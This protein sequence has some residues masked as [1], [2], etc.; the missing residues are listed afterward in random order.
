[1]IG[2]YGVPKLS[3]T[4]Y[5]H[6]DICWCIKCKRIVLMPYNVIYTREQ[7]ICICTSQ[8]A[9]LLYVLIVNWNW[10]SYIGIC[11]ENEEYIYIYIYIYILRENDLACRSKNVY[12]S[13]HGGMGLCYPS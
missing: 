13:M 4:I 11:G 10:W 6:G 12:H 7:K 3:C 5:L 1:M 2:A 9:I 8:L